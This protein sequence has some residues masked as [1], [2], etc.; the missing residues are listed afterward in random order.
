MSEEEE[1]QFTKPL[2]LETLKDEERTLL[3]VIATYAL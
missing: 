2:I 3:G 1:G